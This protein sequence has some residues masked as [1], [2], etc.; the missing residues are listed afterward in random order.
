[1]EKK[2]ITMGMAVF[3]L[4][5]MLVLAR[6]A[7]I[8]TMG[9]GEDRGKTVV[10]DVG[11]GGSD[12]GKVGTNQILEKDINL[13]IALKLEKL[14]KQSD[15][16][17]VMTRREDRGLYKEKAD[18][19]K[20]Q[21]MRARIELIEKEHASLVVSIHQNSFHDPAVCGPQCFYYGGSEEGK[22]IAFLLQER[23]NKGL[24][25]ERPRVA[26]ENA[27]YYLLKKSS[28]PTVIAECG[29]L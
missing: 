7:A 15:L 8:Y 12:P 1:M 19:R 18:N 3:M 29:F 2:K 17:V 21:D 13:Q 9:T 5:A 22:K 16:H 24:E 25:I 27:S 11:H 26:K 14:L 28:V 20:S 23:L 6:Q 10:I 4:A